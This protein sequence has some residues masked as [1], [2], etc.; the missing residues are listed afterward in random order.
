MKPI[1][2]ALGISHKP[3]LERL[4]DDPIL[5]SV[6]T[7]SVTTGADGKRYEMTCLPLRFVFGWLFRIDSRN[8]AEGARAAVEDYQLQCYNALYNFFTRH[9]EFL[10]YRQQLID[11]KLAIYDARRNDFRAAK[12]K[13]DEARKALDE[14]RTITES[15]YFAMKAQLS[16]DFTEGKE[17]VNV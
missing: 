14:A 7:T 17:V 5:S 6:V 15:D 11:E 13:V 1:C 16:L 8:V 10:E 4:K 2:E 3:Q 12:T 9:E